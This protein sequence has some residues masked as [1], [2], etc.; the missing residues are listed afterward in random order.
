MI[1]LILR[2][3]DNLEAFALPAISALLSNCNLPPSI[4]LIARRLRAYSA[5]LTD[6]CRRSVLSVKSFLPIEKQAANKA[7]LYT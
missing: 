7:K 2:Y 3:G 4:T 6:L 5:R 1:P